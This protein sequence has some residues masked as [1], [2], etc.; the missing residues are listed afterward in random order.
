MTVILKDLK[1]Q[2]PPQ[3][4]TEAADKYANDRLVT[5]ER[6][7]AF[8]ALLILRHDDPEEDSPQT[9]AENLEIT[10]DRLYS[11]VP[12][13]F[14][15]NL[16]KSGANFLRNTLMPPRSQALTEAAVRLAIDEETEFPD[17]VAGWSD[18][19]GAV[20]NPSALYDVHYANPRIGTDLITD[21]QRLITRS[22]KLFGRVHNQAVPDNL[23]EL[24]LPY[25]TPADL[26][27]P[28]ALARATQSQIM[29]F[30]THPPQAA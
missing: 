22:I 8:G 18:V 29:E 20:A 25:V 23:G 10:E 3:L 1:F 30:V 28:S 9:V 17:A 27:G 2:F 11:L 24:T 14:K 12:D 13:P 16:K 5:T 15:S 6:L 19:Y 4:A 7:K 26:D 21:H